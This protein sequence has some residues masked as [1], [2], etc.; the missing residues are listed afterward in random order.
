MVIQRLR[1]RKGRIQKKRKVKKETE[2]DKM[3]IMMMSNLKG[4]LIS[5]TMNIYYILDPGTC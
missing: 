5:S 4:R 3:K 2:D 1:K